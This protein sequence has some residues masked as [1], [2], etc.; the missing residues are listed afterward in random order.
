MCYPVFVHVVG[1]PLGRVL[2]ASGHQA[3]VVPLLVDA[4]KTEEELACHLP[5]VLVSQFDFL[6]MVWAR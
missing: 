4:L 2:V 6:D 1:L 5:V 3:P